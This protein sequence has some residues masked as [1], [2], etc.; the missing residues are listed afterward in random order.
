MKELLGSRLK[1]QILLYLMLRGATSGRQI[2]LGLQHSLTPVYKALH[3]LQRAGILEQREKQRGY[4]LNPDYLYYEEL[5]HML[6]KYAEHDDEGLN[7]YQDLL[8][9]ISRSRRV[10]PSHVYKI[11]QVRG[12]ENKPVSVVKLSDQLR[13]L[14]D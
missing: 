2:A 3:H 14:Y 10:D 12:T 11:L 1:V 7:L 6:W 4:R 8:P 5:V 9:S 13:A